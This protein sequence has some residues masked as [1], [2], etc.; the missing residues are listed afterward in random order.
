MEKMPAHRLPAQWFTGQQPAARCLHNGLAV[1]PATGRKP[2]VA[3]PV[4]QEAV[5]THPAGPGPASLR[6]QEIQA[7]PNTRPPAGG[8][9]CETTPFSLRPA[10]SAASLTRLARSAPVK[11]VVCAAREST[12]TSVS[13][14]SWRRPMCTRRISERPCFWRKVGGRGEVSKR[15]GH[16]AVSQGESNPASFGSVEEAAR[17]VGRHSRPSLPAGLAAPPP[18]AGQ[19]APAAA[20]QGQA[21]QDGWWQRC[22]SPTPPARANVLIIKS[23]LHSVGC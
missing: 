21:R 19:S 7:T 18:H 13:S 16:E 12:D 11:P 3:P 20:A 22:R 5:Q 2:P 4:Q 17:P 10:S 14:G 23:V 15:A 8:P 6:Q 1:T 9:T